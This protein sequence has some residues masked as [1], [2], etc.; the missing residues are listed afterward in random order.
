MTIRAVF[1]DYGGVIGRTEFQ[2]PRQHLAERLGKEYE[3]LVGL[4]FGSE[5]SVRASLGQISEDEHWSIVMGKLGLPT[6]E[7]AVV[8]DQFFAG[9]VVDRD[10]LAFLVGLRPEYKVCLVSNA[11][12]GL[13]P[14]LVER[15]YDRA[16]DEMVISAEIG[17]MKPEARIYEMALGKLG[18]AAAESVFVDDFPENVEGA[19]AVGIQ[20]IRFQE[21]EKAKEELM[22]LLHR[23]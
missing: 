22:Q 17:V 21:S 16:F 20:A 12:S 10:L 18:V 3:E 23:R 7:M 13:R 8:R 1:V 11:W 19:R 15:E 6:S 5:S 2:A 14:W 9:D 4:V